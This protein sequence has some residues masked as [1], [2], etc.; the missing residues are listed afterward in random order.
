MTVRQNARMSKIIND[1]RR[2]LYSCTH[3]ATV[4]VKGSMA[5]LVLILIS[6]PP[7]TRV[8]LTAE[9]G[10]GGYSPPPTT[11][12]CQSHCFSNAMS[13]DLTLSD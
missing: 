7:I 8:E 13:D 2:M 5:M 10:G 6:P 3:M 12:C 11:V 9:K 1:A 4:G